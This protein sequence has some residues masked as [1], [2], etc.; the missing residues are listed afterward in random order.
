[1]ETFSHEAS[2]ARLLAVQTIRQ[3]VGSVSGKWLSDE[4]CVQI[5]LACATRQHDELLEFMFNRQVASASAEHNATLAMTHEEWEALFGS[6][7]RPLRTDKIQS[8]FSEQA[9]QACSKNLAS[10]LRTT[11]GEV[12]QGQVWGKTWSKLA[13]VMAIHAESHEDFMSTCL[14][15][16]V[17]ADIRRLEDMRTELDDNGTEIMMLAG[18]IVALSNSVC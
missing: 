5:A 4:N 15:N 6:N 12:S 17:R 9:F 14:G 2:T 11:I 1:M 18:V 8:V 16:L 7:A 13:C 10:A 3:R